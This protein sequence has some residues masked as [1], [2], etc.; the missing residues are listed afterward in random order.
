GWAEYEWRWTQPGF[1]NRNFRQP[2]WNGSDLA[3]KSILLHAEQAAGDILQF[4]RYA[5][6]VKQRGGNVIVEVQPSL[7]KLLAGAKGFD[8]L[9]DRGSAL[10]AFDVHAALTS[11][12]GI[13]R[14]TPSTVPATIPYLKADPGLVNHWEQQLASLRSP[15]S[16]AG[17]NKRTFLV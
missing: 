17:S 2:M 3:G 8:S 1:V 11:L 5:L 6:L 10:P 12:P 16:E 14:T 7:M 4:V 9:L 15:T 13:F